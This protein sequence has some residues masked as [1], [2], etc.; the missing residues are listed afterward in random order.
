MR[1]A[2]STALIS[3]LVLALGVG[4]ASAGGLGVVLSA[5]QEPGPALSVDV[6]ALLQTT[7]DA[8]GLHLGGA[9][10]RSGALLQ[11]GEVAI[12]LPGLDGLGTALSSGVNPLSNL[13]SALVRALHS[14][15]D[16]PALSK[17]LSGT[18]DP[19]TTPLP[20]LGKPSSVALPGLAGLPI[21][22]TQ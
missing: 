18:A 5:P 22:V 10:A 17:T 11:L 2:R 7:G 3:S 19:L 1:L 16:Q 14:S 8:L 13:N 21:S 12:T 6:P 9:Q 15:A 20:G 4:T